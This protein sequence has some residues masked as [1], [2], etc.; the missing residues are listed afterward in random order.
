MLAAILTACGLMTALTS[1]NSD[2][3]KANNVVLT[4]G[5]LAEQ[6]EGIWFCNYEAKGTIADAQTKEAK[7]YSHVIE[8]YQFKKD[9]SSKWLYVVVSLLGQR[10]QGLLCFDAG[11]IVEFATEQCYQ[12]VVLFCYSNLHI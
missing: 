3:D 10:I 1:C 9:G 8:T 7:E 5:P 4:P 2:D 12:P 6:I 11:D